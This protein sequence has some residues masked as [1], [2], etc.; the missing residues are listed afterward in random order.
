MIQFQYAVNAEGQVFD[1]M[2]LPKGMPKAER[3]KNLFCLGCGEAVVLRL[4]L[5]R[6]NHCAHKDTEARRQNRCSG[7]TYLH[8]LGKYKLAEALEEVISSGMKIQVVDPSGT[9]ITHYDYLHHV[10]KTDYKPSVQE[11]D[12]TGSIVS[13]ETGDDAFIPD[14]LVT[15]PDRKIYFEVAVTHE[16][17]E[18]KIS[19]GTAIFEFKLRE[20]EDI[21]R[22][23]AMV[24]S[25]RLTT[26][27]LDMPLAVFNFDLLQHKKVDAPLPSLQ[28]LLADADAL[29]QDML[30]P[31]ETFRILP[32]NEVCEIPPGNAVSIMTTSD[33]DEAYDLCA[34]FEFQFS[35]DRL[36][37]VALLPNTKEEL[38]DTIKGIMEED[39]FDIKFYPATD[40]T[41]YIICGNLAQRCKSW[42]AEMKRLLK[43]Y[44]E[45][46]V[47]IQDRN[48]MRGPSIFE[49]IDRFEVSELTP[50][51]VDA[52]S[53]GEIAYRIAFEPK[54]SESERK[55]FPVM[56]IDISSFGRDSSVSYGI[57]SVF[58]ILTHMRSVTVL[59]EP[60]LAP[61]K[62]RLTPQSIVSK[63]RE[64]I[65][66]VSRNLAVSV[67]PTKSFG[68]QK[69]KISVP[70]HTKDI[71]VIDWIARGK[72]PEV[73]RVNSCLSCKWHSFSN[74]YGP[75]VHCFERKAAVHQTEAAKCDAFKWLPGPALQ[76]QRKKRAAN[77]KANAMEKAMG[78]EPFPEFSKV[79]PIRS[80][81]F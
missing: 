42:A 10:T 79:S 50:N 65:I 43:S 37:I 9:I 22:M 6:K 68:R 1:A 48:L 39:Y 54:F 15:S 11:L 17:E 66:S 77:A 7:E 76:A 16:C 29:L 70:A 12:I 26:G 34:S 67:H 69:M 38:V 53:N 45:H 36:G 73:G 24:K 47:H 57:S 64:L 30:R 40:L 18:Q 71:E 72:M 27:R 58:P 33:V 21:D 81:P 2:A 35:H 31:G 32:D 13:V 75:P 23:V 46:S 14:V 60:K 19:A 56:R 3:P 59:P 44:L 74:G 28:T 41:K 52:I 25:G 8:M 61:P 55:K 63:G 5:D 80:L 4:G 51:H 20:L 49:G 78:K 62:Q